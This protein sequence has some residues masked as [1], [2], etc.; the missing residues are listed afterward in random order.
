MDPVS[1]GVG[2]RVVGRYALH[3]AIASGG[4]A[5]V[6]LG[7][8]LGPVGFSRTVAIKRLHAQYAADPEFVSMFLDEARLVARIRHPNVVQTLDVVAT[9]GELFLVMDY[10]P[11]ESLARLTRGSRRERPSLRIVT[12][13][14]AGVLHGLHAAHEAKDERG[15]PLGI[16][17]RDVSPQNI[18]VG[19]DGVAKLID[20]GV[21]KAAGRVQTTKEGEIKGKLSYM[22]P[23]QLSGGD[24]SRQTDIYAAGVI[25]WELITGKR[26]F[27]GDHEGVIVTKVLEAK[28]LPPSQIL[29]DDA[30]RRTLDAA[31]M[32]GLALL[33]PLIMRA[34]DR[35]PA[36][37]FPTARDLAIELERAMPPAT[38]S[39]V[40]DWVERTAHD[41]LATRA[42]KVAEVE[43]APA[44][45]VDSQSLIQHIALSASQSGPPATAGSGPWPPLPASVRLIQPIPRSAPI[46]P[47]YPVTQPSSIS[48]AHTGLPAPAP[49][50]R[51]SVYALAAIAIGGLLSLGVLGARWLGRDRGAPPVVAQEPATARD[52]LPPPSAPPINL[53]LPGTTTQTVAPAGS[54]AS[55]PASAAPSAPLAPQAGPPRAT[56][57]RPTPPRPPPSAAQPPA[58]DCNPPYFFE[59]GVKKYKP[60]CI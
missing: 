48:V 39:E 36:A 13:V 24:V 14:M 22:P 29:F 31:E 11:G 12:A 51:L 2:E 41:V 42:A 26:L 3:A 1:G 33:D 49:A 20:F 59:G 16:V 40:G 30:K 5:T 55:T 32:R 7:R 23:E 43:G 52:A 25:L 44:P 54:S 17:H 50:S 53:G 58:N 21:A 35:D 27:T 56:T 28:V 10:A 19:T 45:P 4:M 46:E 57:K 18:L 6:H 38:A 34:L 47:A 15:S 8:L 9:A 60:N 37:R